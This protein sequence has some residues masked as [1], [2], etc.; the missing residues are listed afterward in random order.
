MLLVSFRDSLKL[1]SGGQTTSWRVMCQIMSS[2]VR[3]VMVMLIMQSGT[4]L[5]TS[6]CPDQT[7][8]SLRVV[9]ALTSQASGHN[10]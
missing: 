1:S 10:I 2:L 7:S 5:R 4:V 3:L 6:T 8:A 9:L